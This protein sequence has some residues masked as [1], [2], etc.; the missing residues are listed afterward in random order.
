MPRG[1]RQ[2]DRLAMSVAMSVAMAAVLVAGCGIGADSELASL[3]RDSDRV[4]PEVLLHRSQS[5]LR[6]PVRGSVTSESEWRTFLEEAL[7][8]EA[9]RFADTVDFSR[10]FVAVAGMGSRPTGGFNV[11]IPD[12]YVRRDSM[13]VVIRHTI[14]GRDCIVPQVQTSPLEAVALPRMGA[15]VRFVVDERTLSC[16]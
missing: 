12:A 4:R 7:P 11:T 5:D 16:D 10:S 2:G 9:D 13:F 8:R 15:N 14:P 6:E 1:W 3:T